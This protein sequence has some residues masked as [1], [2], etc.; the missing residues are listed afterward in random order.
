MILDILNKGFRLV[1]VMSPKLIRTLL[2]A[3]NEEERAKFQD[4]SGYIIDTH[5]GIE[6]AI[7]RSAG[8]YHLATRVLRK[9]VIEI[10]HV[11]AH[12]QNDCPHCAYL[13]TVYLQRKTLEI[14][15]VYQHTED[16]RKT[17][18]TVPMST[19]NTMETIKRIVKLA[20]E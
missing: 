17:I 3:E 6:Y 16:E 12:H 7:V 9:S 4:G 15:D 14:F 11:M 1:T 10:G 19:R 20:N 18:V 13:F 5:E 2:F 8:K